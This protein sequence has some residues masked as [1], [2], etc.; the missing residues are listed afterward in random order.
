MHFVVHFRTHVPTVHAFLADAAH[1]LEDEIRRRFGIVLDANNPLFEPIYAVATLL[2]PRFSVC[3]DDT[4]RRAA[5]IE[6]LK[7]QK[8]NCFAQPEIIVDL[9]NQDQTGSDT[10]PSSNKKAKFLENL[11]TK[12]KI[13]SKKASVSSPVEEEVERFL[14]MSF[15]LGLD[16]DPLEDWWVKNKS[17]FP[18]LFPV[19][20]DVLVIPATSA[21][22]ER[23]FSLA[24]YCSKEK[25]NRL[26]ND[27]LE[28][29][30]MLKSNKHFM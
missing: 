15:G 22:S 20:C 30:V 16:G 9:S 17:I 6:L 24:G 19:A 18:R 3:L 12:K 4:L 2:D 10:A 28:R 25:K 8:Q 7:L 14:A 11:V 26:S 21:P 13:E 27:H 5:K 1:D 23:V 29:E